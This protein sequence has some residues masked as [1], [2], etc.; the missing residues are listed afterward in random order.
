MRYQ[1]IRALQQ[2]RELAA[3]RTHLAAA[4]RLAASDTEHALLAELA[5]ALA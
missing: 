2:Q 5:A 3:A 1:L 4:T